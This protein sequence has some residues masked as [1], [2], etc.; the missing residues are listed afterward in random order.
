MA[1][2]ILGCFSIFPSSAFLC[3][4]T[5]LIC[6]SLLSLTQSYQDL[7]CSNYKQMKNH[8]VFICVN[9]IVR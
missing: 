6:Y 5:I 3:F 1:G 4:I 8:H 7:S 9:Q 2:F